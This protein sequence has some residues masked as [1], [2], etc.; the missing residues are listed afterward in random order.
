MYAPERYL[1]KT[2]R[3]AG[4]TVLG[5]RPMRWCRTSYYM[6]VLSI[7]TRG[8]RPTLPP[9]VTHIEAHAICCLP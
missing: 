1:V 9:G 4:S 6:H 7:I 3:L 5:L 2:G 8:D